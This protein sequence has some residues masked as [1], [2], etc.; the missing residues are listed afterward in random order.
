MKTSTLSFIQILLPTFCLLTF[1]SASAANEENQLILSYDEALEY[2]SK[3]YDLGVSLNTDSA[4]YYGQQAIDYFSEFDDHKKDLGTAYYRMGITYSSSLDY[5]ASIP[6]TDSAIHYLSIA[7]DSAMHGH[8]LRHQGV[9]YHFV[10][11]E[12][13]AVEYYFKS[14]S[15]FEEL[16]HHAYQG[17]LHIDLGNLFSDLQ[18]LEEAQEYYQ[19]AID[20]LET[21]DCLPNELPNAYNGLGIV[22]NGKNEDAH[23]HYLEALSGYKSMNDQSG[24]A[25][26]LNNIGKNFL[27]VRQ[28]HESA[29]RYFH[30]ARKIAKSESLEHTLSDIYINLGSIHTNEGNFDSA[31]VSIQKG[32]DL[33]HQHSQSGILR[34]GL[35]EL[36]ELKRKTER[37]QDALIAKDS[38]YRVNEK[39]LDNEQLIY[40]KLEQVRYSVHQL[41]VE[42]EHLKREQELSTIIISQKESRNTILFICLTLVF[43]LLILISLNRS[44]LKSSKKELEASKASLQENNESLKRLNTF[45]ESILSVVGHDLRGY[46]ASNSSLIHLLKPNTKQNELLEMLETSN[47]A[48]LDILS[49]LVNW[50]RTAQTDK[51]ELESFNLMACVNNNIQKSS[52]FFENKNI[53]VTTNINPT[54]QV[55]AS[56]EALDVVLRNLL[57]NAS[58]FTPRNK[59]VSVNCIS[60]TEDQIEVQVINQ[61]DP[62]PDDV[63]ASILG[64]F[65]VTGTL[66]TNNEKGLGIG[67]QIVIFMLNFLDSSLQIKNLENGPCVSFKLNSGR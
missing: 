28:D 44:K 33:A 35:N 65:N 64:G 42:N 29:K 45:Q 52:I 55:I 10:G 66:G 36:A 59:E 43:L 2:S 60:L 21:C 38:A 20:F 23:E 56:S 19:T 22:T 1:L 46:L 63:I 9:N 54:Q 31:E 5:D 13:I 18:G 17:M 6:Y 50:S 41:K 14:L 4:I 40:S 8:A 7:K 53:K 26:A 25:V 48:A 47:S 49:D 61:G 32:I 27:S 39:I 34:N 62:I 51:L 3:C 37:Y 67:L 30:E 24:H 57:T 15:I 11:K 12:P 16:D 58:K